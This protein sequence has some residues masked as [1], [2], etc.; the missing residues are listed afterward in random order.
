MPYHLAGEGGRRIEALEGQT[1]RKVG[2]SYILIYLGL[3]VKYLSQTA[4]WPIAVIAPP[5]K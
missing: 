4:I 3:N 1:S 5:E 2:S